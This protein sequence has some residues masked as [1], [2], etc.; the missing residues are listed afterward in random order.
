ML[1]CPLHSSFSLVSSH[2]IKGQKKPNSP[3]QASSADFPISLLS[4]HSSVLTYDKIQ[5]RWE[6]NG[7]SDGKQLK[8]ALYTPLASSPPPLAKLSS[9]KPP[10]SSYLAATN[11]VL[12]RFVNHFVDLGFPDLDLDFVYFVITL[13][14]F[15]I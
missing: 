13:F 11:K 4:P 14:F 6:K 9:V 7:S 15:I 1:V 3:L 12:I 5:L 2:H 8:V 10:P